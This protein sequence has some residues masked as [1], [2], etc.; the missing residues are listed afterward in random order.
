MLSIG[1]GMGNPPAHSLML[2]FSMQAALP[3]PLYFFD[4]VDAALDTLNAARVARYIESQAACPAGPPKA[5]LSAGGPAAFLAPAAHM[6]TAAD[7][8]A[9]PASSKPAA[10]GGTGFQVVQAGQAVHGAQ[11][12]VVSHRPQVFE[13]AG[14]LVGVYSQG[15]SAKAVVA[16]F[17]GV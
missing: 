5:A 10:A 7:D 13:R 14:S 12:I 17:R 4:E 16:A 8:A 9:G 15:G 3:S 11:Y 6:R 1:V 2:L